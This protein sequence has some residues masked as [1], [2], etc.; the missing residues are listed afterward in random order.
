M[1]TVPG[2]L[3]LVSGPLR[4]LHEVHV[5]LW[6]LYRPQDRQVIHGTMRPPGFVTTSGDS[7]CRINTHFYHS[8]ALQMSTE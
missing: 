3:P 7:A 4:V 6:S 5:H 8:I 1:S 2:V